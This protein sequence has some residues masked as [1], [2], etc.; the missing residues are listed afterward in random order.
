MSIHRV[1]KSL[2]EE[3]VQNVVTESHSLGESENTDF[4]PVLQIEKS[5]H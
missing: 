2:L 1:F 4:L 5:K 3:S